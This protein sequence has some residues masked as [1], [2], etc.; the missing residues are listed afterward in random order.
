MLTLGNHSIT[1][2]YGG[3]ANF[4]ASTSA[5]LNEQVITATAPSITTQ[6]VAQVVCTGQVVTFT[7][8]ASGSPAPTVQWQI[9]VS[10]GPFSNIPQS[11][12][13]ALTLIASTLLDGNQ[14]RAIFT[15]RLGRPPLS[16]L[17]FR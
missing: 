2:A 6:P 12:S 10:N 5:A 16:Q 15:N 17:R 13:P 9:S 1:A 8:A 4:K 3:D 11:N 14:Y 7:A